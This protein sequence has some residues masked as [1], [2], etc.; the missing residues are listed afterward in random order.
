MSGSYKWTTR[1]ERFIE[2]IKL[3]TFYDIAVGMAQRAGLHPVVIGNASP[4]VL[5]EQELQTVEPFA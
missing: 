5:H 2:W 3:I 4:G 1:Y